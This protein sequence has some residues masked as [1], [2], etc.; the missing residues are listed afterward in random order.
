MSSGADLRHSSDP[1]F[2]WLWYRLEAAALILPLA[3]ELL[4]AVGGPKFN[5]YS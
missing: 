2:L 1:E 4:Y 3:W 5:T